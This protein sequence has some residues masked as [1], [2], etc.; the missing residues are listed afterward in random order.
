MW[1]LK[2]NT[3]LDSLYQQSNFFHLE[4]DLNIHAHGK[5]WLKYI[6]YSYIKIY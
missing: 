3:V 5:K 6:I 1:E 4:S 2:K